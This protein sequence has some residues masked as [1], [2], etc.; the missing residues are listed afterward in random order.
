MDARELFQLQIYTLFESNSQLT[1]HICLSSV[2]VSAAN[3]HIIRKQFTTCAV[4]RRFPQ[5]L[6][7]LQIYTNF[8]ILV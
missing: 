5:E 3:I 4:S 2:T 6:F 7:Q 8:E 1:Y